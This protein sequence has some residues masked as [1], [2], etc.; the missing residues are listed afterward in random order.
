MNEIPRN[1]AKLDVAHC[2]PDKQNTNQD[3]Q[4]KAPSIL[5]IPLQTVSFRTCTGNAADRFQTVVYHNILSN[6]LFANQE[7][8]LD[9][10]A[11]LTSV[12]L[13]SADASERL[14]PAAT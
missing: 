14:K 5:T 13:S 2:E 6:C 12:I 8:N 10:I 4:K 3:S 7:S 1:S 9:Q 11:I